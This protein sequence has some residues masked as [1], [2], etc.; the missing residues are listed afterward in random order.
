MQPTHNDTKRQHILTLDGLRALAILAIV[1][2]HLKAP[3]LPSGNL[4]VIIFL[5]LSGYLFASSCE[6]RLK[7]ASPK[8]LPRTWWHRVKRVWPPMA[9][10]IVVTTLLCLV[11]NHV[12]LTKL[13]PDFIPSLLLVSNLASIVRGE[14]YCAQIGGPSPFTHLWYLGLDMQFVIVWSALAFLLGKRLPQKAKLPATLAL[15]AASA[16]EMALLFQPEADPTRV[17]YGLDTRLFAPL[18]GAVLALA[19]PLKKVHPPLGKLRGLE[20]KKLDLAG[21]VAAAVL[22]LMMIVVPDTSPFNYRGGMALGAVLSAVLIASLLQR[23]AAKRGNKL[24]AVLSSGPM[25]W[26]GSRSFSL[27]LWHFPVIQL[28]DATSSFYMSVLA[29]AISVGLAELSCRF[30]ENGKLPHAI[31]G[32]FQSLKTLTGQGEADSADGAAADSADADRAAHA[33]AGTAVKADAGRPAHAARHSR[34]TRRGDAPQRQAHV[35]LPQAK[36]PAKTRKAANPLAP[37]FLTVCAFVVCFL[38]IAL[39]P[40]ESLVPQDAIVNTGTG[41]GEAMQVDKQA[42]NSH[43]GQIV[44][45]ASGNPVSSQQDGSVPQ[46]KIVLTAPASEVNSGVRDP[47]MIGDSVPGDAQTQ[48]SEYFPNG[49]LDSYVGR[50][51]A[52][53]NKVLK[54][55]LDQGV[56]GNV[57]IL[58]AFANNNISDTDLD[59]MIESC[60]DRSVFLVTCHSDG[61][62]YTNQFN[63]AIKR[64]ADRHDNVKV[65]DWYEYSKDNMSKWIY[66]DGIHLREEGKEPYIQLIANTVAEDF[67]KKGGTVSQGAQQGDDNAANAN[68]QSANSN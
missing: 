37:A 15:A 54:G 60:G 61:S 26:L 45:D 2:Y 51:P 14:S 4:G 29:V 27:Y 41:A 63:D 20:G 67:A 64:A 21:Y 59:A 34:G 36:K 7:D 25:Q 6:G 31:A 24:A 44:L 12:L 49:L 65:I 55:Y 66:D 53:M 5:V 32:S 9:L 68:D 47:V 17:Y 1:L 10:M 8:D 42:D 39:V 58:E 33:K 40:D 52:Q 46:G 19:W 16:I 50:T 13:K 22:L 30:V 3:W 18:A 38:A 43:T 62:T 28:L 57:V 23:G 11:F 56:V 48:F 35:K